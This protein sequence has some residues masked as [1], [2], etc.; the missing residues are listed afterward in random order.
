MKNS[1]DNTI[2]NEKAY[3]SIGTKKKSRLIFYIS[4]MA[5]PIIQFLV[6]YV[7]INLDSFSLA[8]QKY[9]FEEGYMFNGFNNFID[10]FASF[11]TDVS[12]SFSVKNSL[13]LFLW[14]IIFGSGVAI[15]FSYYIYKENLGHGVFKI[16]LYLPQIL[17]SVVITIMYKYFIEVAI[18]ELALTLFGAEI[19]GLLTNPATVKPAIIFYTIYIGFGTQVLVYSSTMSGISD[20]VI[21]SAQLEG[22]TPVKELVFIILPS[23]WATFVTFM[24]TSVVSIFTNQM[25]LFTLYSTS[26]QPTLYTFGYYLF[27]NVAIADATEY[28]F[29]SA[30]GLLLSAFAV[31]ITL[32][33]RWA[34]TKFGPS[35]T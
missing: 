20:S 19:E 25:S 35:D 1:V 15:L 10:V 8:F 13:E 21:E 31:P 26:A 5:L 7:Y 6:F 2:T 32:V 12:L 29:L 18:P 11:N 14:S 33:T 3:A 23:I 24:V 34:L 4:M 9:S 27:R 22:I 16:L 28:P 30:L 17:G